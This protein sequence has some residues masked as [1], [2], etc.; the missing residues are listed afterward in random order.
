MKYIF[1]AGIVFGLIYA[2]VKYF[3][4]DGPSKPVTETVSKLRQSKIKAL[5]AKSVSELIQV[6]SAVQNF[7]VT[8][9]RLPKSLGELKDKGYVG[10][11]PGDLSYD[12]ATGDV[13]ENP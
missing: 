5:A 6:K 12:P 4:G 8:E 9:G 11:I 2:G 1:Y 10:T 13:S 7:R 3:A